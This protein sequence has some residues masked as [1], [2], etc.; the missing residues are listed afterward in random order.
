MTTNGSGYDAQVHQAEG[1]VSV[2][3]DCTMAEARVKMNERAKLLDCTLHDLAQG[4]VAHRIW[5][6]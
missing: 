6:R 3:A 4:V 1:V 5:F 2:Q